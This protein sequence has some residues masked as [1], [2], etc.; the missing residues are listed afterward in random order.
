MSAARRLR[1]AL[2]LLAALSAVAPGLHAIT[3]P[4]PAGSEVLDATC[5]PIKDKER[6]TIVRRVRVVTRDSTERI[7]FRTAAGEIVALRLSE[8][9]SVELQPGPVDR[10]GFTPSK[11]DLVASNL[12][13]DAIMLAP[14]R[15]PVRLAGFSDSRVPVEIRLQD[16]RRLEIAPPGRATTP[17]PPV[18]PSR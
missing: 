1:R 9:R 2:P 16:C 12:R 10:A 8:I 4:R 17:A 3:P 7:Q 14:G 18:T 15:E 13:V 5:H 6:I 11:V